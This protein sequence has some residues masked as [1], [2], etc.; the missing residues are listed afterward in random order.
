MQ[1]IEMPNWGG[2]V[3]YPVQR[4]DSWFELNL[5]GKY[6]VDPA[7]LVEVYSAGEFTNGASSWS[8]AYADCTHKALLIKSSIQPIKQETCR[9]VLKA[10]VAC[11]HGPTTELWKVLDRAKAALDREK[12]G[13][14]E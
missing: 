7:D 2:P 12:V 8:K 11:E 9:D 14:G 10:L 1:K 13:S 3:P 5:K 4:L 6:I